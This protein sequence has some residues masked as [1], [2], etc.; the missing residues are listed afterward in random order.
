MFQEGREGRRGRAAKCTCRENRRRSLCLLVCPE[1]HVLLTS[2]A[3]QGQSLAVPLV[4]RFESTSPLPVSCFAWSTCS[5]A[6]TLVGG[7]FS[8]GPRQG[9][10]HRREKTH[11]D[12]A[13]CP[14]QRQ[15]SENL[16]SS[17][18]AGRGC[19]KKLDT[20]VGL[21]QGQG[22]EHQG[23]GG[24]GRRGQRVRFMWGWWVCSGRRKASYWGRFLA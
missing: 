23:P 13:V 15:G 24:G 6:V 5:E 14:A 18:L 7:C 10:K 11:G 22:Q 9:G 12:I 21:G 4:A 20:E 3:S 19:L 1:G 16:S 2:Q 8:A 17:W